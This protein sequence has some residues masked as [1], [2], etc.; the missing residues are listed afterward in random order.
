MFTANGL[1]VSSRVFRISRRSFSGSLKIADATMPRAPAL[2]IAATKGAS[3]RSIMVPP[4]IGYFIPS[5][6]VILVLNMATPIHER[7]EI[8]SENPRDTQSFPEHNQS[9]L[10][11]TSDAADD[12]LCV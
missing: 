3:E 2:E 12:L 5:N 4:M 9:C 7:F 11:Y 6:S 1:S 10:L 8:F